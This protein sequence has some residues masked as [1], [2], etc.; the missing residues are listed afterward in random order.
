ME[1]GPFGIRANAIAPGCVEG[2][3]IDSVIE[4]EA[5]KKKTTSDVIREAGGVTSLTDLSRIEI[6][7]DVPLGKGGGKKR[8]IIDLNSYINNSDPINDIRIFDGDSLFFPKLIKKDR[9][10]IS[11]SILSGITPKFISVN[12]Y[13]L[14]L[15]HISEPTRP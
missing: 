15:I 11:K 14:S 7:R 2:A 1:A 10:Q 4:K 12:I 9:S 13:G 8:A 5:A 3:R 6:I